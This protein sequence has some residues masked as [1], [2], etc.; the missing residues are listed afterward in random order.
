M[1]KP[2]GDILVEEEVISRKTLERALARQKAEGKRLGEVLEDMGVLTAQ[3]LAEALQYQQMINP[4]SGGKRQLGDILVKAGIISKHTLKRAL[5]RQR[6]EGKRLGEVLAAMGVVSELE[7]VEALGRQ[8]AFKT[9]TDFSG[10]TFETGLLALFPTEF[11][12]RRMVFPLQQKD[13]MLA[14]AITDPF[15][16]DTLEKVANITGLQVVPVIATRSE[17]LV[18]ISRHYLKTPVNPD[19]G[20]GILVADDSAT[21]ATVIQNSLVKEGF[22]VEIAKDGIGAAKQVLLQRPRLVITEAVLP[23]LDGY[24]LLR[25]IKSNPLTADIPVIMLSGRASAEDEKNAFEAGFFDVIAK[26]VQP[27][28]VATRVKRA[29]EITRRLYNT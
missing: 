9:V 3:E 4:S 20:D 21:I 27:V 22:S 8:F 11:V 29:L 5:E 6:T 7:L 2:L 28:R 14:L 26:P 15:D 18:A 12:M 24:G 16:Q 17:L 10:R 13:R 23:G 25:S 1:A 19:A